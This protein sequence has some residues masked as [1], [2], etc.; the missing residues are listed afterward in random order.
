M[1]LTIFYSF[2][3]FPTKMKRSR[4]MNRFVKNGTANFGRT[5]PDEISGPPPEVIPNVVVRRN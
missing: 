5:G 2:S 3:K 4:A 1:A